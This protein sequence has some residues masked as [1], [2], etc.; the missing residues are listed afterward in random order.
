M[1]GGFFGSISRFALGEWIHSYN[2]FPIG[3]LFINLLGCFVLGW[4][5]PYMKQKKAGKEYLLLLISTGFI[6]SFTTFSTFSVE[7]LH[8]I[9]N[10]DF[11]EAF[12]YVYTSV[13]IGIFCSFL[14]WKLAVSKNKEDTAV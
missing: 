2:G 9:E 13:I 14:G 1:I 8:L 3:T 5:I 11:I 7:S 6:G 10:N 4:F 12:I